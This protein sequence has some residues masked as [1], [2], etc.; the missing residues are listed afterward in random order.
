[1]TQLMS[2]AYSVNGAYCTVLCS[3]T[4]NKGAMRRTSKK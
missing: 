4:G 1:M 3:F 2:R